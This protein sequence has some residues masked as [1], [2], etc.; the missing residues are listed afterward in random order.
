[1]T[2]LLRKAFAPVDIA[3][4]VYARIVFGVMMFVEMFRFMGYGWIRRYYIDPSFTFGY[5]FFE[6]VK[7][8]PPLLM[9]QVFHV[10]TLCALAI[11]LGLFY[12][13]AAF[14]FAVGITYVFLLD[15]TNYLNHIYLI[16]L[17]SFI[18]ALL[19]AAAAGSLDAKRRKKTQQFVPAWTLW[20]LVGQIA[21]VYV[22]GGIA[23]LD[24]DWLGGYP[25]RRF[26]EGWDV[27]SPLASSELG[28][29]AFAISGLL[30]DLF[31]VPALL[32]RRTRW[33][34]T[35]AAA[36]FHLTN[37]KLFSIGIFPWLMLFL[38]PV[39]W[40]APLVRTILERAKI[41]SINRRQQPEMFPYSPW[42]IRAL[43]AY[44]VVQLL[45]PLRHWL[46]PGQVNWTEEGHNF[47]WHMKLRLKN[48]RT[49]FVVT[50]RST[51]ES[52][53]VDPAAFLTPRQ[54]RKMTTRPD[55]IVLF[56]H[57]LGTRLREKGVDPIVKARA[58]ASLNG[59]PPQYLID[60][61]V[62]LMTRKRSLLPADWI[63]PLGGGPPLA[64]EDAQLLRVSDD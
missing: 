19:P 45:M 21:L 29:K 33:L 60:P 37:A 53:R 11:A 50:D 10:M 49:Y 61:N 54:Q 31:I 52:Q 17:V 47:S 62:D 42:I 27:T 18:F 3:P 22:Y 57:E 4:L 44:A 1:M 55:M 56:A 64:A 30:F 14:I 63:V 6:W 36:V 40:P 7:P 20:L 5:H 46:Y 41:L 58:V 8:L 59:R 43:V 23:K 39:F 35:F 32:W 34:A 13:V 48:G 51:G 26:L 9:Y 25:A 38:T 15:Q 16:C 28:R 12:R 24:L 2:S